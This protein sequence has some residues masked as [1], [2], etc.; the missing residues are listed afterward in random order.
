MR[1][2][3]HYYSEELKKKLEMLRA[4]KATVLE[5]PSGFGKTTA[6]R[7]C[8]ESN[9]PFG[10]PVFWF[11]AADEDPASGYRRLCRE[12][13]HIDP[14]A[15]D[16]LVKTG[17]PNSITIGEACD[18][19]RR[20]HCNNDAYLVIDN[21]QLFSDCLPI[22]FTCA[23]LDHGGEKLHV[24][25][26]TQ[27]VRRNLLAFLGSHGVNHLTATALRMSAADIQTYYAAAGQPI[28]HQS[29]LKIEH[30]TEGWAA[31]V[32]LHLR[33]LLETGSLSSAPD[34]HTMMESLLWDGLTEYQ[35]TFLLRVSPLGSFT[36]QEA[37]ILCGCGSLT[38]EAL[39]ALVNPF[40]RFDPRERRY[41]L[42]SIFSELLVV[43][44][45]ERGSWF[46]RECSIGA[47]DLCRG[48]GR[49]LQ[50]LEYY[51]QARAFGRILEMDLSLFYTERP[52]GTPFYKLARDIAD[53]TSDE[54][55]SAKPLAMLQVA[56]TLLSAGMVNAFR[57]LMM[58]LRPLLKE[59]GDE[60]ALLLADW[61]L[62]S[63]F[64]FFP[65][66]NQM[67][68]ILKQAAI[69]F[70]SRRSRVIFPDS[71]WSYSVYSPLFVFHRLPG[72]L[73]SEATAVQ[74]YFDLYSK[75]TGGHGS[76]AD[77][78]FRMEC[79]HFS[80]KF[81]T[82]EILAYKTVFVA[83]S[84]K[85]TLLLQTAAFHLA[86][87][88]LKKGDSAGWRNAVGILVGIASDVLRKSF[89]LTSAADTARFMMLSELGVE[90][91]SV[92]DWL[93][94]GDFSVAHLPDQAA[95][96]MALH[97]SLV[98]DDKKAA[99]IVGTVEAA[100]PHGIKAGT[101]CDALLILT[102]AGG[103]LELHRRS[104]AAAL[105]GQAVDFLARD[106]LF[107]N[108]VF[109]N[110]MTGGLVAECMAQQ[111]PSYLEQFAQ[112]KAR[113]LESLASVYPEIFPDELPEKL[114]GREREIALLAAGGLR[115]EE[116][117]E[118]LY[119]SVNTVRAHLRIV[120]RKLNIDRRAKLAE[121]LR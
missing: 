8:L 115:N 42:H 89:V 105:I 65:E 5:A 15:G 70:R 94:E 53:N 25:L 2:D 83:Q 111:C 54:E 79:A 41:E 26:I 38:D 106:G 4:A 81:D 52:G 1:Q 66:P 112:A 63:S 77:V 32:Y 99:R 109:Y 43:K 64:F 61:T 36:M 27:I 86:M 24:V 13:E 55:A 7:D 17:L 98:L 60:G 31:A 3:I 100:Y 92:P 51:I 62:L 116:I 34:I 75:L 21:F 57:E 74:G 113:M 12:I 82:A 97:L 20:L 37:C 87:L 30:N 19:L 107:S 47:G 91:D 121:M 114:T 18:A 39:E 40:I 56:Y 46:D 11:A 45:T 84:H 110:Q 90:N 69:L 73:E 104:Q 120:F 23:L 48:Q 85:Q 119:V 71:P 118:R 59:E 88:A 50:A 68:A 6:V 29:A 22:S 95:L 78:L 35:Q 101:I 14:Q 16:R 80:C 49:L 28:D 67:S 33:A 44:S 9:L 76:G 10:T 96:L 72:Q 103:Y 117:A 93:R 108:L 102:A 58:R